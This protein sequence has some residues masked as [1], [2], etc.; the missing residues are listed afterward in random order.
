MGIMQISQIIITDWVGIGRL[1]G[2]E[3]GADLMIF[4]DGCITLQL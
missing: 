2:L 4:G 3:D 1:H